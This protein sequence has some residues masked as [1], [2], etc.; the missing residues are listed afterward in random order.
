MMRAM[1]VLHQAQVAERST[2]TFFSVVRFV[3]LAAGEAASASLN[4]EAERLVMGEVIVWAYTDGV[5]KTSFVVRNG[6]VVL[7]LL[8]YM[9][10]WPMSND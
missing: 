5:D 6:V 10:L 4:G 7:M 8:K 1:V 3:R 9:P 2:T